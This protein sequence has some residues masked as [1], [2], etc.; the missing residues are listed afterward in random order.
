M[1]SLTTK[2]VAINKATG[3]KKEEVEVSLASFN[4]GLHHNEVFETIKRLSSR[5]PRS[6]GFEIKIYHFD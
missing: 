4:E 1:S 6:K 3:E 2:I 5:F